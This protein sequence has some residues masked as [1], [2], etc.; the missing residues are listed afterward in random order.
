MQQNERCIYSIEKGLCLVEV[1]IG[2]VR[3]RTY[4]QEWTRVRNPTCLVETSTRNKPH[5]F[6]VL[7]N[8]FNI[9]RINCNNL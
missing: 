8:H 1:F 5:P 7:T 4:V 9:V 3:I 6:Q 2:H